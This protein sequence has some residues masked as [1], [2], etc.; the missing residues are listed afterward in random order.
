MTAANTPPAPPRDKDPGK[1]ISYDSRTGEDQKAVKKTVTSVIFEY[2]L[3]T[4]KGNVANTETNDEKNGEKNG[5]KTT[6]ETKFEWKLHT[7]MVTWILMMD[8]SALFRELE[9]GTTGT[10]SKAC[11]IPQQQAEFKKFF[12]WEHIES[13]NTNKVIVRAIIDS[14]YTLWELKKNV[15]PNFWQE[16]IKNKVWIRKHNFR[17]LLISRLGFLQGVHPD[18]AWRQT[19]EVDLRHRMRFILQKRFQAKLRKAALEEKA[20]AREA[21]ANDDT[22]DEAKETN[23]DSTKRQ[24]SD[25]DEMDAEN[26]SDGS[27]SLSSTD[28]D[29]E[30]S[31][32]SDSHLSC[33]EEDEILVQAHDQAKK[34][35]YPDFDLQYTDVYHGEGAGRYHTRALEIRCETE[36]VPY[37]RDLLMDLTEAAKP[38]EPT[39]MAYMFSKSENQDH[40]EAFIGAIKNQ[41][42]YLADIKRIT[43]MGLDPYVMYEEL[44]DEHGIEKPLT[45]HFPE[46]V[47]DGHKHT[48]LSSFERTALARSNGKCFILCE[49]KHL[50]TME[51]FLDGPFISIYQAAVQQMEDRGS[52]ARTYRWHPY[53][54][55]NERHLPDHRNDRYA[56]GLIKRFAK[57][58]ARRSDE[59][60][61]FRSAPP[62]E[63]RL[64]KRSKVTFNNIY[65]KNRAQEQ[66]SAW[67]NPTATSATSESQENPQAAKTSETPTETTP[68]D[69][70]SGLEQRFTNL[71]TQVSDL[72]KTLQTQANT[73]ATTQEAP[74]YL[75][76]LNT[77][78][79]NLEGRLDKLI[80]VFSKPADQSATQVEEGR[81][82]SLEKTVANLD[83]EMN[84]RRTNT[85]FDEKITD[86]LRG[87]LHHITNSFEGKVKDA[88][89]DRLGKNPTAVPDCADNVTMSLLKSMEGAMEKR[90]NDKIDQKLGQVSTMV[91]TQVNNLS[92]ELNSNMGACFVALSA[93]MTTQMGTIIQQNMASLGL[94]QPQSQP[95]VTPMALQRELANQQQRHHSQQHQLQPQQRQP[96]S[97]YNQQQERMLD[98]CSILDGALARH[99]GAPSSTASSD[100]DSSDAMETSTSAPPEPGSNIQQ[101]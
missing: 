26:E 19:H 64:L 37:M 85:R 13:D 12:E 6:D 35:F 96:H 1:N 99:P 5:E 59:S 11:E 46:I 87:S 71:E 88:I 98:D 93:D 48:I 32:D 9:E 24:R 33:A 94:A 101:E 60:T 42:E 10:I 29:T 86:H 73:K 20:K 68:T 97:P 95:V 70:T 3:P 27:E 76:G 28:T 16:L 58:T 66:A 15:D 84:P 30:F 39:F 40:Q 7:K 49:S 17:S 61:D 22:T 54:R 18:F 51:K 62:P 34:A 83:G 91:N 82:T 36:N 2:V 92:K 44:D 78:M 21:A 74:D 89:Q 4:K 38:G 75:A 67:A 41:N 47:T 57:S 69:K 79:S 65:T 43:M 77:R 52:W 90:L 100:M 23:K 14:K 56:A 80:N 50:K 25:S 31:E 72:V 45:D 63:D 53:P 81:L 8:P 55:R